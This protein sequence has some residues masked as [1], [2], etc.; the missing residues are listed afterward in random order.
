MRKNDLCQ[1][2]QGESSTVGH[3]YSRYGRYVLSACLHSS[4][5]LSSLLD[6]VEIISTGIFAFVIA[7]IITLGKKETCDSLEE[8]Y[9]KAGFR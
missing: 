6:G 8:P 7:L 2:H 1:Q 5:G 3:N 4:S 9:K